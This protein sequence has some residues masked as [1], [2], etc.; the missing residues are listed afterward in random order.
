MSVFYVCVC[1]RERKKVVRLS[2][3]A[4]PLPKGLL[5]YSILLRLS[6]LIEVGSESLRILPICRCEAKFQDA[7]VEAN[8][9]QLGRTSRKVK[10]ALQICHKQETQNQKLKGFSD[11]LLL[12]C[13]Y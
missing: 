10:S 12:P 9:R 4:S 2:S 7:L 13:L 11:F 3:S 8:W 1:E 5:S 6:I